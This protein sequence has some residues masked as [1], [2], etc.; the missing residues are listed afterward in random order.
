MVFQ[1][2]DPWKITNLVRKKL[3]MEQQV[4]MWESR[5]MHKAPELNPGYGLPLEQVWRVPHIHA[6][7]WRKWCIG[8]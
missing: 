8:R 3:P 7:N 4:E 5:H 1:L 2:L 6:A